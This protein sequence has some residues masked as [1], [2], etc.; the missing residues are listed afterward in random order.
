MSSNQG[1]LISILMPVKNAEPFLHECLSS[2]LSQTETYWELIAVDDHSTDN[3]LHILNSFAKGDERMTI[4][5]NTGSMIID[6]LRTAYANCKGNLITRMDADDRMVEQKLEILKQSLLGEGTGNVAIGQVEYFSDTTLG[7]GY[8][9][10]EKWLNDM[11]ANGTNYQDIYRECVI[12]SPCW[13]VFREDLDRCAAFKPTVY[14]EDYDLCFRFYQDGLKPIPCSSVLHEWRDHAA[15]SSRNDPHYADNRFLKLKL[16]WFLNIDRDPEKT[17]VV[18][19]AAK[20]GKELAKGL[21]KAK[22]DFR[23]MCNNPNKIGKHVYDKLIYN[24]DAIQELDDPQIII[25]VANKDEQAEIRRTLI[26]L[27]LRSGN[28]FFFFC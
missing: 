19:G 13:M 24:V 26:S 6:A 18:W 8:R 28:G 4:L 15:R 20:K 12:P 10:Y 22:V 27:G 16:H 14:P 5:S 2:I 21:L 3:S 25:A 9:Y 17:L 7:D 23:W 11:A 1:D